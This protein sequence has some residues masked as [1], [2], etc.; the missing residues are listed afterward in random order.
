M[1]FPN[2]LSCARDQNRLE[3]DS[4]L[5]CGLPWLRLDLTCPQFSQYVLDAAVTQSTDWR[6][7]WNLTAPLYQVRNWN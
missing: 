1:T 7:Q 6:S 3:L 5:G 4:I 2:L